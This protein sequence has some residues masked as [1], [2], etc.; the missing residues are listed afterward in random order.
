MVAEN[1]LYIN[2]LNDNIGIDQLLLALIGCDT[3]VGMNFLRIEAVSC[4]GYTP[5]TCETHD[6]LVELLRRSISIEV[7]GR[8]SLRVALASLTDDGCGC[9]VTTTFAERFRTC[10][11]EN[12]TTG[13]CALL[14]Y[15]AGPQ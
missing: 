13:N 14:I 4:D 12:T 1:D 11:C 2:C 15:Y 9:G 3:D 6:T 10:F 7:D 5:I 8:P